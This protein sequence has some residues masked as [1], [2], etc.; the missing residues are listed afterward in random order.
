MVK[1]PTHSGAVRVVI[2]DAQQLGKLTLRPMPWAKDLTIEET[3][4]LAE[5]T[6]ARHQGMWEDYQEQLKLSARFRGAS[7]NRSGADRGQSTG[8]CLLQIR[9]FPLRSPPLV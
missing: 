4:A 2:G 8:Q 5:E 1:S 9:P 7:A 6:E 3:E